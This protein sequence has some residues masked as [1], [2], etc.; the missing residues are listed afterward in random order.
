MHEHLADVFE[1]TMKALEQSL[2]VRLIAS[3]PIEACEP[4]T[5]PAEAFS[6]ESWKGYDFIGVREAHKIVGVLDRLAWEKGGSC[7]KPVTEG[8]VIEAETSLSSAIERLAGQDFL[9][10]RE[11]RVV[12]GILTRSDLLKLPVRLLA[13]AHVTHLELILAKAISLS[14]K[15]PTEKWLDLLP[16]KR[17]KKLEDKLA[18]LK[19]ER[20]DLSLL[21]LTEFCD[22][23]DL[24]K[25]IY[26]VNGTFRKDLS[27]IEKLLRNPVAHAATFVP[28]EDGAARLVHL[29]GR[30]KHWSRAVR[31]EYRG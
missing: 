17:K 28:R 27:E 15:G 24:V 12:S 13:F 3:F 7:K 23:R 10:V 20:L 22:K 18:H 30:A 2:Q 11:R 9:L 8:L 4:G 6:K 25:R 5:P 14:A 21:E 26:Q 19:G 29:L 31:R 16:L 1:K